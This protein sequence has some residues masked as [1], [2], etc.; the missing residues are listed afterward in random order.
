MVA[1][2][3]LHASTVVRPGELFSRG[4]QQAPNAALAMLRSYDETR[5]APKKAIRMKERDPMKGQKAEDTLPR[6]G[7]ENR[8]IA[9]S[10]SLAKA[11]FRLRGRRWIT[12][13]RQELGNAGSIVALRAADRRG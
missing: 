5:N 12:Q 11:P 6:L 10:G 3:E 1:T 4:D 2:G 13:C 9:G 7:D 8:R